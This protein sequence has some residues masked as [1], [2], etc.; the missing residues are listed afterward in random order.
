MPGETHGQVAGVV[1]RG[2]LLWI[3]QKTEASKVVRGGET[4]LGKGQFQG[5]NQS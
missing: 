2:F 5:V 3:N 1:R 4:L